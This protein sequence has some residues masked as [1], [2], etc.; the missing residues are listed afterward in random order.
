M[1]Q[2]KAL[3]DSTAGILYSFFCTLCGLC[4][5][6][7]ALSVARKPP[8]V[9]WAT[10]VL[11]K[12]IFQRKAR[13]DNQES[14]QQ[15]TVFPRFGVKEITLRSPSRL[16]CRMTWTFAL[17]IFSLPTSTLVISRRSAK[18][19]KRPLIRRLTDDVVPP[20]TTLSDPWSY[21]AHGSLALPF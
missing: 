17:N 9:A 16:P 18:R 19:N 6:C 2:K 20:F 3:T 11:K 13:N 15:E 14:S 1:T 7:L 21:A 4:L 10:F 5:S 8:G 12:K